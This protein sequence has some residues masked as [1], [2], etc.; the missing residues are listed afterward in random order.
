M[1]QLGRSPEPGLFSV[2]LL[3]LGIILPVL[4]FSQNERSEPVYRLA[5]G[6]KVSVTVYGQEDLSGQ[7]EVDDTG[8]ISMP[9]IDEIQAV[10][11]TLG[12][13]E[14]AMIVQ[15]KPDYLKNPRISVEIL[16]YQP[17]YI[18]GEVNNPGRYEYA[19][20]MTMINAIALAGGF[21]HRANKNNVQIERSEDD[22]QTQ[23][24]AEP[25]TVILPGDVIEVRERFF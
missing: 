18:F 10:G 23:T 11:M 5:T 8:N 6:D 17:F 7:Y 20:G 12:D 16:N 13:L 15:Y 19:R 14:D 3:V 21:T 22:Q 9:L 2:V 25:N 4:C 24:K 1:K